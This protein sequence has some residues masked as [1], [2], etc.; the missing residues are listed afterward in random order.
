MGCGTAEKGNSVAP[1]NAVSHILWGDEAFEQETFS[2][3]Y[4]APGLALNT[5]ANI[6]WAIL[7]EKWFGRAANRGEAGTALTGEPS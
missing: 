5:A 3:K 2:A 7:F 1:I 4:T 6:S